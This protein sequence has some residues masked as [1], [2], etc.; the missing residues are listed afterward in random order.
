MPGFPVPDWEPVSDLELRH[1][2]YHQSGIGTSYR[3]WT[4]SELESL[5]DNRMGTMSWLLGTF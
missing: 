2:H 1:G 5:I 3:E 4:V